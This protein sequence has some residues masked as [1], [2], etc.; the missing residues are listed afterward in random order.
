MI[1]PNEIEGIVSDINRS[2]QPYTPDD[3]SMEELS[4]L[5][6]DTLIGNGVSSRIITYS[7]NGK[8]CWSVQYY[9]QGK[10]YNF[11]YTGLNLLFQPIYN[12]TIQPTNI[13]KQEVITSG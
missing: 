11:N 13:I 5:I 2:F 8:Q 1:L 7:Y 6:F 9:K 12:R 10:W 4:H 3:V